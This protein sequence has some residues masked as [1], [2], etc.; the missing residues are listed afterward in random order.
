MGL[1]TTEL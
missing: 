1:G